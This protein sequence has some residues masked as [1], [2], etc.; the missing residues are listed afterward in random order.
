[1][2][3]S[4]PTV[5]QIK[6][7][8]GYLSPTTH[9]YMIGTIGPGEWIGEEIVIPN[10]TYILSCITNSNAK[11]LMIKSAHLIK[12][13]QDLGGAIEKCSLNKMKWV[14]QRMQDIT[15]SINIDKLDRNAY[16]QYEYSCQLLKQYPQ[17]TFNALKSFQKNSTSGNT[18]RIRRYLCTP[19]SSIKKEPSRNN[20]ISRPVDTGLLRPYTTHPKQ[21]P[22]DE[23]FVNKTQRS[24]KRNIGDYVHLRQTSMLKNEEGIAMS[25][26]FRM[27]P[28]IRRMAC[29]EYKDVHNESMN[30]YK[31]IHNEI[32]SKHSTFTLAQKKISIKDL[33]KNN[34]SP[35]PYDQWKLNNK[36]VL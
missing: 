25:P 32:A 3:K 21:R 19:P 5:H 14:N 20:L 4:M 22:N 31:R 34:N 30:I 26:L 7:M 9:S 2:D 23:S 8:Q 10:T 29:I 27:K 12:L 15:K 28:K 1:M 17:A 35:N 11:L 36:T 24:I 18:N 13:N 33:R 16:K 6:N